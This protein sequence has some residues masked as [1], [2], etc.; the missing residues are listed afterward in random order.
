MAC[1][2]EKISCLWNKNEIKA[3]TKIVG[4]K[5]TNIELTWINVFSEIQRILL[6]EL[7]QTKS[8]F[9]EILFCKYN[10]WLVFAGFGFWFKLDKFTRKRTRKNT[11]KR[12]AGK[13]NKSKT[14]LNLFDQIDD[15]NQITAIK[16]YLIKT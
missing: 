5:K 15:C 9:L 14:V 13:R 1:V 3:Q 2:K 6:L 11:R 16:Y 4:P 7:S 12:K 10:L 8:V